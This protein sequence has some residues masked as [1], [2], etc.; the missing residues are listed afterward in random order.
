MHSSF[1]A[2]HKLQITDLVVSGQKTN[3]PFFTM[4]SLLTTVSF[5]FIYHTWQFIMFTIFAITVCIFSYS[6]SLSF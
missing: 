3:F 6:F 2:E 1:A 4:I 5:A